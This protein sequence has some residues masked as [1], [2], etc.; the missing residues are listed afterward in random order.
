MAVSILKRISFNG[1]LLFWLS[2][3]PI[4]AET[5]TSIPLNPSFCCILLL[6]VSA[7]SITFCLLVLPFITTINS[8]PESRT[9]VAC[10]IH[11]S[12]IFATAIKSPSP[13]LCPYVS[14]TILKLSRSK[15]IN[16][17]IVPF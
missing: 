9:H 3:I 1:S 16:W 7:A 13:V 10:S 6:I 11:V 17:R 2:K 8:S 12:S 15:N 14:L 4:L 5:S